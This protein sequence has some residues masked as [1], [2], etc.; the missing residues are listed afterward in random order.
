MIYPR[1]KIARDL[2]ADDGVIFISID[3]SEVENLKKLC[4]E[5][6]GS[7]N[8]VAQVIVQTNPRGRTFDRFI[9]K[10]TSIF[11]YIQKT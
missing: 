1:L 5:I 6:F 7:A 9:A 3:D 10:L 2:L 4:N 11:L 8:F